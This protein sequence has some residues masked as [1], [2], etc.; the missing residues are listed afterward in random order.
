MATP[1]TSPRI[2]R[3]QLIGLLHDLVKRGRISRAQA[4]QFLIAFDAGTLPPDVIPLLRPA[5]NDL[6]RAALAAALA[7]FLAFLASGYKQMVLDGQPVPEPTRRTI[8]LRFE[9]IFRREMDEL[10]ASLTQNGLVGLWQGS[11]ELAIANLIARQYV[12]GTGRRLT[13]REKAEVMALVA[14]QQP[15]LTRFATEVAAKF[16][17]GNA[18]S[19]KALAARSR[20][21]GA[22]GRE[23]FYRGIETSKGNATGTVVYYEAVDDERTCPACRAA[24]AGSPYLPGQHP[25]PG[26]ICFGGDRCR[27]RL[28]Y[29]YEPKTWERLTG[30][31]LLVA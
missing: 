17:T 20:L 7:L 22:A 1:S 19:A 8:S 23:A 4:Q 3:L 12:A 25:W 15:F 31:K 2:K 27:C 16:I 13:T 14:R 5:S 11:L 10:A 9:L 28:R 6:S 29:E 26:T 21:Y 24:E 30:Q 18:P